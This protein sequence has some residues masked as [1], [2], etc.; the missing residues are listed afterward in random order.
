MKAKGFKIWGFGYGI[1]GDLIMS[2]PMLTY[3]EKKYP[4]SYK[5]WAIYKKC[6]QCAPIYFNHPL[7]DRIKITDE[8]CTDN[9]GVL[10]F[11]RK[12][13]HA[14]NSLSRTL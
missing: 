8:I 12:W 14:T 1:I 4:E 5:I 3:Y 6:A 11:W 13:M 2:L 10:I 9:M 7:I